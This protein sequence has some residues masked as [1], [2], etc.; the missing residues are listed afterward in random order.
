[1]IG[2]IGPLGQGGP[3]LRRTLSAH[4]LGG[5]LGGGLAGVFLGSLGVVFAHLWP[6]GQR[7]ALLVG[8]PI[9]CLYLGC[10]DLGLIQRIRVTPSRQTPQSWK[11]SLGSNGACIAWGADLG[12]GLTTRA[13]YQGS[14]LIPAFAV[15][16]G[17]LVLGVAIM[18]LH[19]LTRAA[20]VTLTLQSSGDRWSE[21]AERLVSSYGRFQKVVGASSVCLGLALTI[22]ELVQRFG[23]HG[24]PLGVWRV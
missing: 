8:L 13:S 1:M 3:K 24:F 11:C 14:L 21:S 18:V 7:L 9:L 12:S 20:L 6:S 10:V 23:L 5:A 16:A 2:Q 4:L 22:A 19:G 17:S 15:L